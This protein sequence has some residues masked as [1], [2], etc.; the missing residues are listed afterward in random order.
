MMWF[1]RSASP[2]R[3]WGDR[4]ARRHARRGSKIPEGDRSFFA[5]C[6]ANLKS[7]GRHADGSGDHSQGKASFTYYGE[8]PCF[9]EPVIGRR[10]APT[11]WPHSQNNRLTFV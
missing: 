4:V 3:L 9:A 2:A 5:S 6:S 8:R 1:G 10:F 11:R 7:R